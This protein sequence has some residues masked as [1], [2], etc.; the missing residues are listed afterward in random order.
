MSVLRQINPSPFV[1]DVGLTAATSGL[2]ILSIVVVMR[3]L[4]KGLGADGFGAYSLV[5]QAVSTLMPF[6]TLGAAVAI[7]RYIA[8]SNDSRARNGYLLS[9][10]LIIVFSCGIIFTS[11]VLFRGQL[12]A[13]IFH[14]KSYSTLVVGTL[15]MAVG[16][17]LFSVL[18]SFYRGSGKMGMA[19][20]WQLAVMA[21][22][23]LAVAYFYAGPGSAD[24]VVFSM[25][26]LSLAA[27][28]PLARNICP[29]VA[30]EWNA[31]RHGG[32]AKELLGY[33]LPRVPGGF[34]FAGIMA[35]GPFLAPHVGSLKGAGYLL[36]GQSLF[37]VAEGG[38]EAFGTVALPKFAQL[39]SEEK[40]VFLRGRITDVVA[41]VF[42]MGLFG[43]LHLFIWSDALVPAWLGSEYE[44]S[45]PLVR[46]LALALVPYLGFVMLRSIIDAVQKRAV[47]TINLCIS[48]VVTLA[49]SVFFSRMGFGLAGLAAGTA[50]GVTALGFLSVRYLWKAYR[51]EAK[52][53]MV[54]EC[55]AL[56][57]ALALVSVVTRHL[58]ETA[59]TGAPLLL[60]AVAVELM[61]IS[62]YCAGLWKMR[63]WWMVELKNRVF[64]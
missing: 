32:R 57:A 19:N 23:P 55:I 33:G 60:A 10:F 56:N 24:I 11:G 30:R 59:L 50:L 6:C 36:V 51:L 44:D 35:V 22:G 2:T 8:M 15:F 18:Y 48:F 31:M 7:A 62:V 45:V 12:A 39:L 29:A 21:V 38:M 13:L 40:K 41:L 49:F 25:G 47:N 28:V 4:A 46:I 54:K 53:V 1:K 16:Y 9:G 26:A 14:E 34:A 42:H 5:R 43:A 64:V 20:L 58:L 52:A 61:I 27:L 17:A 63:A 3:L 37:R